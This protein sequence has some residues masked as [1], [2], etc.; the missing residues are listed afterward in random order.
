MPKSEVL[1]SIVERAASWPRDAQEELAYV[2]QE[3]EAELAAGVY[4]PTDDELRGIDRG[5]RDAADGKFVSEAEV[6]AVF[7]KHR[8]E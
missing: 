8:G 2:A 1:N 3:I 5:L 6:E 7:A 4:R